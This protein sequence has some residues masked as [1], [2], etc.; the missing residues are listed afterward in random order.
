MT[1]F[2]IAEKAKEDLRSIWNYTYDTWSEEQ[3]DQYLKELM[4]EF[5]TIVNYPERGRNYSEISSEIF[6]V[7]KN[8]HIIF[9][10]ILQT[11]E[12]EIIRILHELMD[13]PRRMKE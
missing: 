8:R 7:K 11:R 13:L 6:G 12:V 2:R 9:Y 3:A 4:N 5:S 1:A 10:R